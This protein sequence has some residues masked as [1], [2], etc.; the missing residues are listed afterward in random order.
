MIFAS[1]LPGLARAFSGWGEAREYRSG[2]HEG[3]DLTAPVGTPVYAVAGGI[4]DQ[5]VNS[6]CNSAGLH[7]GVT[8][9]DG[10]RTVYMH[11]SRI[12]VRE[13]QQVASGQQLGLSGRTGGGQTGP[14]CTFSSSTPDHLHLSV[15]RHTSRLAEHVTYGT[16]HGSYANVP[17]EPVIPA[18]YD[19]DIVDRIRQWGLS[20]AGAAVGGGLLALALAFAL[21]WWWLRRRRQ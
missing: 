7:V 8:H 19:R 21:T 4:V 1:P 6:P 3:I 13:G 10:W 11:F 15:M 18:N 9:D 12:D 20:P 5:V 17:A 2:V 16:A 14:G